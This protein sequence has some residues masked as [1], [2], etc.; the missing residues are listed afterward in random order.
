MHSNLKKVKLTLRIKIIFYQ[1]LNKLVVC[2]C[3]IDCNVGYSAV[4]SDMASS[5]DT[6]A[7]SWEKSANCIEYNIL[8]VKMIS[9]CWSN[10]WVRFLAFIRYIFSFTFCSSLLCSSFHM[11]TNS[12]RHMCVH[13]NSSFILHI[14]IMNS[15]IYYIQHNI[16]L[17][18]K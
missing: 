8:H 11:H 5:S 15:C 18:S 17:L 13:T 7:L 3:S 6:D 1:N 9:V 14:S 2:L 12:L 16:A 4:T 10:R